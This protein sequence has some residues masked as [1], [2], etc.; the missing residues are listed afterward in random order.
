M[1]DTDV[2]ESP[3]WISHE[4]V[5]A[6]PIEDEGRILVGDVDGPDAELRS[7]V[8][9][10]AAESQRELTTTR[11]A[12]AGG[13]DADV[14]GTLLNGREPQLAADADPKKLESYTVKVG[15]ADKP[16]K[17]WLEQDNAKFMPSLVLNGKAQPPK[18]PAGSG[19]AGGAT[20]YVSSYLN[21]KKGADTK[22][23]SG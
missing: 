14:L 22:G 2:D 4:R 21:R 10:S 15:D 16:L 23:S 9:Q 12:Q 19:S 17:D 20:D 18:A 6:A 3:A 11:I 8:A 5:V 13:Y 7:P 1:R